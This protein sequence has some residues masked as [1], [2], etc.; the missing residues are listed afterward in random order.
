MS[1]A[2]KKMAKMMK[3]DR[4]RQNDNSL[5]FKMKNKW[6]QFIKFIL[7]FLHK[8]PRWVDIYYAGF[9]CIVM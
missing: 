3:K 1:V 2:K 5:S 6:E 8:R 4:K 9:V 7:F